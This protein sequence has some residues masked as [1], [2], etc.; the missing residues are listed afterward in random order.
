[1]EEEKLR[2]L[3]NFN[4]IIRSLK[5]IKKFSIRAVGYKASKIKKFLSNECK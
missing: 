3:K 1:L 2:L 4:W 5:E